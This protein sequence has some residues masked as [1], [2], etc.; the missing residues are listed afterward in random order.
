MLGFK[1][2]HKINT[3]SVCILTTVE[4]AGNQSRGE[5]VCVVGN[6]VKGFWKLTASKSNS[7][8]KKETIS[9]AW[10]VAEWIT[11]LMCK[12]Q[13][14]HELVWV[15]NPNTPTGD[16]RQTGPHQSCLN[17]RQLTNQSSWRGHGETSLGNVEKLLAHF[18]PSQAKCRSEWCRIFWYLITF[19]ED[20]P[21]QLPA[22]RRPA[23]LVYGAAMKPRLKQSEV[24]DQ[25]LRQSSDLHT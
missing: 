20:L 21:E 24:K 8:G 15:C 10:D 6:G 23:S 19:P 1:K 22:A 2:L 18:H 5:L 11:P 17:W 13:S 16:G 14:P 3:Q 12:S 9:C 4:L 25:H 7:N